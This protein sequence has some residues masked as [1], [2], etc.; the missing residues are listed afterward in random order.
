[1][2]VPCVK[3]NGI[4]TSVALTS[5]MMAMSGVVSF[6]SPDEVVL[7]V[8]EVGEKLHR[9]YKETAGGGLA[10]TRDGLRVASEFRKEVERFF[11]D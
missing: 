10:R 4:Y 5:A 1:V 2:E 3:R 8:R 11:R 9:D 6:V 7:A